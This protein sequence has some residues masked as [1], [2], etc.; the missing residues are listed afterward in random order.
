M[1]VGAVKLG[2]EIE[3]T[4]LNDRNLT[5]GYKNRMLWVNAEV[6]GWVDAL[7]G[8]RRRSRTQANPAPVLSAVAHPVL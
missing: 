7:H 3:V 2:C 4:Q 5:K 8:S 6:R 1:Q